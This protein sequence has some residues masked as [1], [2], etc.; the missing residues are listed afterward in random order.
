MWRGWW[1]I[2]GGAYWQVEAIGAVSILCFSILDGLSV[3]GGDDMI[4]FA[5]AS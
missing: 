2:K 3:G 1:R 5:G 4:N